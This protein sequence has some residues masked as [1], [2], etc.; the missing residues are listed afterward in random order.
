MSEPTKGLKGGCKENTRQRA[1]QQVLVLT[2][3]ASSPGPQL[4]ATAEQGYTPSQMQPDGIALL[5][6]E[7][8]G[9][10]QSCG[11]CGVWEEL[12]PAGLG[13]CCLAAVCSWQPCS[14]VRSV[15][16]V[17]PCN[18]WALYTSSSSP[19]RESALKSASYASY[20]LLWLLIWCKR[21]AKR[22]YCSKL[23][24][25]HW[26]ML[27]RG[28]LSVLGSFSWHPGVMPAHLLWWGLLVV[29]PRAFP[30]SNVCLHY[31]NIWR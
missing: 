26:D 29:A 23:A 21:K 19:E 15:T 6:Q 2:Q 22:K 17:L 30:L 13:W 31:L 11:A 4:R 28:L 10:E 8:L 7:W 18:R 27:P 1:E 20:F 14:C 3:T 9:E 24:S 16:H 5:P 25:S 12:G